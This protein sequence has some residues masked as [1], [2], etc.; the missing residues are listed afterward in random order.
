MSGAKNCPETT[1]QK[2]I[3]MMYLVL[4]A[5]L[6]LNVSTQ[7]LHGFTLVDNSLHET[8]ES[9]AEITSNLYD[10]FEIASNN[11]AGKVASWWKIAKDVREKS[12]SLFNYIENFKKEMLDMSKIEDSLKTAG[13]LPDEGID[14]L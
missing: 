1:R 5:M 7:V 9:T 10:A 8:I 13:L 11:N 4:T 3:G 6:A 14:N 12:D 2:M